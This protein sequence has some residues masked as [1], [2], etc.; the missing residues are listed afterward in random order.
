MIY[1]NVNIRNPW[2]V[3][4]WE[5]I[6]SKTGKT[7]WKNKFWE[8]EL[9]KDSELFRIEFNWTHRQDHAGVQLE[10][11]LLGYKGSFTFY[12]SRHWDDETGDWKV[13]DK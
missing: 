12:D 6:L 11:G 8:F 3:D 5:K 9:M 2:W 4:R 13:Y 10:L 7:L 1:F